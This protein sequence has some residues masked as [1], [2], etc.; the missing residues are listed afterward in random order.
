[1]PRPRRILLNAASLISLILLIATFIFWARG[2]S[3]TRDT[4]VHYS[5]SPEKQT[6]TW[7][8]A[9]SHRGSI[10]ILF[11]KRTWRSPEAYHDREVIAADDYPGLTFHSNQS[12]VSDLAPLWL[13]PGFDV[14]YSSAVP[15]GKSLAAQSVI[16]L[17]VP[18][19]FLLALFS[20]LPLLR[21]FRHFRSTQRRKT[22]LCPSCGY[23]L[24]ATPTLC[25]EC[26]AVP[27]EVIA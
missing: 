16:G 3:Y 10:A 22:G 6:T 14:L 21:L 1:V 25:P 17:S 5:R 12:P 7:I 4:V 9:G 26:G 19:W 24:R 11:F 8:L 20:V 13:K 2:S 15:G 18:H 27:K 23:D